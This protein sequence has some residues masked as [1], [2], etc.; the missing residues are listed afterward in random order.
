MSFYCIM[1]EAGEVILQQ[2]LPTTAYALRRTF[3]RRREVR[4]A[5]ETGRH[6]P[7]LCGLLTELGHECITHARNLRFIGEPMA[8]AFG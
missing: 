8:I 3:D 1:D 6:S 5:L 2:K 4:V 7:W